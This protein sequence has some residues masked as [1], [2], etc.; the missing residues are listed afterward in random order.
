MRAYD[1]RHPIH[2]ETICSSGD[3]G[4]MD[5]KHTKWH[6]VTMPLGRNGKVSETLSYV[7]FE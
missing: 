3:L 4:W 2:H 7:L 6:Q 5:R 1:N